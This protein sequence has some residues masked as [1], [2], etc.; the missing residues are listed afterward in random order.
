M[1]TRAACAEAWRGFPT[2]QNE[3]G[4]S[5]ATCPL[6][7]G[8]R[9]APEWP[10]CPIRTRT[11]PRILLGKSHRVQHTRLLILILKLESPA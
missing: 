2:L 6:S 9:T 10:G 7:P 1:G 4:Q 8:P 5:A 11:A 3:L